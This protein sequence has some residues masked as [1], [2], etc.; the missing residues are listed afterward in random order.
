MDDLDPAAGTMPS[1]WETPL[2][3]P[4]G[5]R[6][7]G[8]PKGARNKTTIAIEALLDGAA[9]ALTG[10]L[11]ETALAGDGVALR[12]C[13]GRLL[14]ARRD[15]PVAFDLPE[16][17]GA[18]DLVKAARAILAAC[19]GGVL[20]PREATDV[21]GLIATHFRTLKLTAREATPAE[22]ER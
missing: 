4:S 8:R 10:K 7:R 6:S 17:A 22:L 20:S 9:E 11:I 14:P 16:I 13:L 18:G 12:F 15:R 21:M 19:A 2:M 3:S 1:G 5:R